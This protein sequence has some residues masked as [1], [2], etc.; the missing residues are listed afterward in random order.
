MVAIWF[1]SF[2]IQ[3]S[4]R[5][6]FFGFVLRTRA[7]VCYILFDFL[8]SLYAIFSD[9]FRTCFYFSFISQFQFYLFFSS[10]YFVKYV[11]LVWSVRDFRWFGNWSILNAWESICCIHNILARLCV[12]VHVFVLPSLYLIWVAVKFHLSLAIYVCS[13]ISAPLL[14]LSP[15]VC[16]HFPIKIEIVIENKN[17]EKEKKKQINGKYAKLSI[18]HRNVNCL[19]FSPHSIVVDKVHHP[20]YMWQSFFFVFEI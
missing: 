3:R 16:I 6:F 17:R 1:Y 11:W 19:F 7:I 9:K 5:F 20:M 18:I 2:S 14:S 4:F 10:F 12:C 15:Y 13:Y 8:V